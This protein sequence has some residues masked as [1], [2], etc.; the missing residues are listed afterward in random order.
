[1]LDVYLS[2]RSL[3]MDELTTRLT[4]VATIFLPLTFLTGFFGQNFGWLVRHIRQPGAFWASASAACSLSIAIAYGPTCAAMRRAT[5]VR[6][7][8]IRGLPTKHERG[9]EP[10]AVDVTQVSR[11]DTEPGELPE[12]MA[13][14]VIRE[15]R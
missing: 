13:A 10:V 7:V 1:M 6:R 9:S 2:M 8:A 14:W 12:T 11:V 4:I 3:R 5:S 15:E